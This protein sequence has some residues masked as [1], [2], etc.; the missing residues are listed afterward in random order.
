M[1]FV[2][3]LKFKG[4]FNGAAKSLIENWSRLLALVIPHVKPNTKKFEEA[5]TSIEI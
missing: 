2:D 1:K 4:G 3:I 5:R